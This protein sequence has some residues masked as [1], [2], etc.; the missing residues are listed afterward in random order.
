MTPFLAACAAVILVILWD[1]W[2]GPNNGVTP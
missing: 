2:N 1:R